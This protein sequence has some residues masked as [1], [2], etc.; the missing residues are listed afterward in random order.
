MIKFFRHIRQKMIKQN[1]ISNYLLYAIGEIILVMIGI[2]LALQVNNWNENKKNLRVVQDYYCR[3]LAD[4]NQDA[5]NINGLIADCK[6]RL[7]KSNE[8]LHELQGISPDKQKSTSILLAASARISYP[9]TPISTGYDD[10]KSSGNLNNFTDQVLIDQLGTY[11]QEA[12]G[13]AGNITYNGQTGLGEMF[14]IDDFYAMGMIDNPFLSGGIDTTIVSLKSLDRTAL[15]PSQ[16]K[17]LKHLSSVL[18]ALNYRNL[19]HYQSIL[20]KNK[21]LKP[22]LEAKCKTKVV[23]LKTK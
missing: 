6:S 20:T 14:E 21:D 16:I 8:L 23:S 7:K 9:F 15:T 4:L 2:L 22:I 13:L 11:L 12:K 18:I 17:K 19:Q 10:L 5:S 3:F 1:R